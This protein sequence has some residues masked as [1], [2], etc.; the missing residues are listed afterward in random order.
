MSKITN[1][2]IFTVLYSLG[3]PKKLSI[4]LVYDIWGSNDSGI[5]K[6]EELRHHELQSHYPKIYRQR[7][8]LK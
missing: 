3:L 7:K 5:Y 6:F 8:Y 4:S 1:R 2:S